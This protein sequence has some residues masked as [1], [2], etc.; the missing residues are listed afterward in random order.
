L[1]LVRRVAF[2]RG[3]PKKMQSRYVGPCQV[4]RRVTPVSFQIADLRHARAPEGFYVFTAHVSQLKRWKLPVVEGDDL[5]DWSD[6]DDEDS[7]T[8]AAEP[9]GLAGSAESEDG[10]E[11]FG[12][13]TVPDPQASDGLDWLDEATPLRSMYESVRPEGAAAEETGGRRPTRARRPPAWMEDYVWY[14]P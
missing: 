13:A 7:S 14:P 3:Y 9:E 12:W 8:D 10:A 11:D 1:V 5:E 2:K 4:F 6:E